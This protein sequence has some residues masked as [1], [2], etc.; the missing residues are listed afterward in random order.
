MIASNSATVIGSQF[1]VE[2]AGA[3]FGLGEPMR[4]V[5]R[6]R[7]IF[8]LRCEETPA[9]RLIIFFEIGEGI[10]E[11]FLISGRFR[12]PNLAEEVTFSAQNIKMSESVRCIVTAH[13]H[14]IFLFI[15]PEQ[16]NDELENSTPEQ[17]VLTENLESIIKMN[18]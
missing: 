11:G 3:F 14:D 4:V 6:P 1:L 18:P 12:E 9:V 7:G 5:G 13:L 8:D 16:D 10:F 2:P 17:D 15:S